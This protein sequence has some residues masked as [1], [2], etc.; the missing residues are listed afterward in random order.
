[1]EDVQQFLES[2][3]TPNFIYTD[4]SLEFGNDCEDLLLQRLTVPRQMVLLS[5]QYAG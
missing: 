4:S 1:M 5:W 2:R 3:A